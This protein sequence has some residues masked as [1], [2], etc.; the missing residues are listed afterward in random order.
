MAKITAK[1]LKD[2]YFKFFKDREHKVIPS[3]PLIPEND[4]S[5]LFISAGMQPL[6]PYLLGEPHPLGKRLVSIQE[7]VRTVDIIEVGDGFHHTWFEMLGNWSL[8]DYWKEE[9]LLW[10]YEFLTKNLKIDPQ[11]ISVS[12]FGG[13]Q[14]APRDN[15]SAK[16]WKKLGIPQERICF[17]G[18]KE[19][20]WGP[21]GTTGPCGPDSEIF[22]N[23]G[24]KKCSPGCNL[25]CQCGKYIE[26]WNNVFMEY[27]R[28]ADGSYEKLKQ[29]NIDT[30][31]GLE[32]MIAILNGFGEDD[33]RTSVFASLINIIEKLSGKIY[34]NGEHQR[35]MRIIADHLRSAV[36][37]AAD[38]VEPGNKEQGYVL[39]RLIRR[40][41][42]QGKLLGVDKPFVSRVAQAVFTNQDNYGG[43]YPELEKGKEDILAVFKKEEER[44]R[45][46]VGR[47]LQ[48]IEKIISQ[49][50]GKTISGEKAFFVYETFG[51]PLEMIIEETAK[52]GK[53]LDEKGFLKALEAHRKKSQTAAK[54][55]FKGGLSGD[56]EKVVAYHTCTHLLL[57]V[58]REVLEKEVL[59]MG[60]NITEERLRFDFTFDRALSEKEVREIEKIVNQKIKEDLEVRMKVVDLDRALKEG[61]L[62]VPGV[63]YPSQVK[64]YSVGD[65]SKEICGGPHVRKTGILGKFKISKQES[66]GQDKRRIY[67]ILE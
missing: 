23:T 43:E 40:A 16:V 8:G 44:F 33:Y 14:N 32:R 21:A 1:E 53:E 9:S 26:I 6:A 28:K 36:F 22:I 2:K 15:E 5:T 59:Q 64:V 3:A 62:R 18:K 39:R 52:A 13:N 56:S 11:K 10:S 54:G 48:E 60:S 46:T 47:G 29:K 38:G 34:V 35:E 31:M 25:S 63:S 45:A 30:G 50:K 12:C 24:K 41:V 65:F 67:A 37:I 51:F 55:K 19:N 17:F 66:L 61:A 7:A 27:N 4:P 42:R 49:T 58:L 20:W 57:Q